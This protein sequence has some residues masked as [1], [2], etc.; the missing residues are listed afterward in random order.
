MNETLDLAD[1]RSDGIEI[2]TVTFAHPD[3]EGTGEMELIATSSHA[4]RSRARGTAFHMYRDA[5]WLDATYTVTSVQAFTPE[6][7]TETT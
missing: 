1:H 2:Y 7:R 3:Y 6:W 5:R 4:A